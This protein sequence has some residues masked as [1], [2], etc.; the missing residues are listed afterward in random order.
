LDEKSEKVK[1]NLPEIDD[2]KTKAEDLADIKS[3]IK[4]EHPIGDDSDIFGNDDE[5]EDGNDESYESE[6]EDHNVIEETQ[7]GSQLLQYPTDAKVISVES[8]RNKMKGVV[9]FMV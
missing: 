1:V 3:E 2:T 6:C 9:N 5:Q 8:M 7:K 4:N